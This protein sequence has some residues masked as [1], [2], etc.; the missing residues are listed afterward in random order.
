MCVTLAV[1]GHTVEWQSYT[2]THTWMRVIMN[3]PIYSFI[4]HLR[5]KFNMLLPLRFGQQALEKVGG[6]ARIKASQS[7][8]C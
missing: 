5:H 6:S 3:N 7:R 4:L 1:G 2:H 8:E